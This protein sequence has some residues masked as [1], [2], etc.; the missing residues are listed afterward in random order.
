[1]GAADDRLDQHGVVGVVERD[2]LVA[3]V[4]EGP[5]ALLEVPRHL[6]GPVVDVAGG[7]QLVAGVVEGLEG[8]V[9][10]VPVLRVHVLPDDR[11]PLA[12]HFGGGRHHH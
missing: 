12:S 6:L 3:L 1:M 7:D 10:L 5:A 8:R 2:Q 9:E 11:L 4:R